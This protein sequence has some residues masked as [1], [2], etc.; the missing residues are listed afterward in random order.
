MRHATARRTRLAAS[1]RGTVRAAFGPRRTEPSNARGHVCNHDW[2]MNETEIQ[3]LLGQS[4]GGYQLT[5]VLGAGGSAVVFRGESVLDARIVRAIR[6]IDPEA[7]QDPSFRARFAEEA[8]ILER[9]Q[10]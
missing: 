9:L 8:S 1:E 7:S 10:H 6:I 2:P 3:R 4:V 5:A